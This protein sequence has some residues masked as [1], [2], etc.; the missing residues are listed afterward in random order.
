M[1]V[2]VELIDE[3]TLSLVSITILSV[4]RGMRFVAGSV[5]L[6][7]IIQIS[8]KVWDVTT[9]SNR[10]EEFEESSQTLE[11]QLRRKLGRNC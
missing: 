3:S 5:R 1:D 10:Y 2:S 9:D 7:T 11:R 6:S 8:V 4:T